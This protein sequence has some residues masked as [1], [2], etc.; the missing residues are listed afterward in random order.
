MPGRILHVVQVTT[1]RI[2]VNALRFRSDHRQSAMWLGGDRSTFFRS[3]FVKVTL[4]LSQRTL[5]VAHHVIE[6]WNHSGCRRRW[7]N[8]IIS[9]SF[10]WL[11]VWTVD[12]F[13]GAAQMLRFVKRTGRQSASA[14]ADTVRLRWHRRT[15]RSA[16][17][18]SLYVQ[19]D[20]I[21]AV[22]NQ[23]GRLLMIHPLC[24]LAVDVRHD[25]TVA[26]TTTLG[27]RTVVDLILVG[28]KKSSK[29]QILWI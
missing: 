1:D 22:L 24:R 23:I 15:E 20:L 27:R 19:G 21:R 11:R 9:L 13:V 25:V 29:K 7:W 14:R 3:L 17:L 12:T 10:E 8:A 16:D 5:E 26:Q 2:I 28:L 18:R 4:F 6:T